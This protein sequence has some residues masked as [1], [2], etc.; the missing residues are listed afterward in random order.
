MTYVSSISGDAN[1][2]RHFE[3]IDDQRA[4]RSTKTAK[5]GN[6]MATT[7]DE[8]RRASSKFKRTASFEFRLI[9]VAAFAMFLVAGIVERLLPVAWLRRDV[10]AR[11]SI[12]EQAKQAANTCAAYA[13][14]G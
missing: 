1:G 7:I 12:I 14:M 10:R 11:R 13:F 2:W 6:A 5:E 4:D 3:I 8:R 9:Y